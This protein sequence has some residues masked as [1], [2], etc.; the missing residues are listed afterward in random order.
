[1]AGHAHSHRAI[2]VAGAARA[3]VCGEGPEIGGGA[4]L[5]GGGGVA[6]AG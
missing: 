1:M 4:G 5:A 6:R 3:G 2:V